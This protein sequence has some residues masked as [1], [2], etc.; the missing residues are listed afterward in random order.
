MRNERHAVLT[1]VSV[2]RARKS[3]STTLS[4]YRMHLKIVKGRL[5]L[6]CMTV[7]ING[8]KVINIR[9]LIVHLN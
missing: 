8:H 5:A 3:V 2:P 1:S 4:T 9:A 6:N 7:A